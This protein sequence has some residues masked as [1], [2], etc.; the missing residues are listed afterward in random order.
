MNDANNSLNEVSPEPSKPSPSRKDEPS[1]ASPHLTPSEIE[2]LRK[3][4]KQVSTYARGKFDD[5][6]EK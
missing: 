4:G 2:S 3:H 1:S 6:F 5:L